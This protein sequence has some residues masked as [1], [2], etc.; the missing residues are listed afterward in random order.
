MSTNLKVTICGDVC[1]ECPRY[2]ATQEND[3]TSLEKIAELWYKLGL[4][5]KI[6][7]ADELKCFGCTKD[8][9]CTHQLNKCV[10]LTNKNN[11]GECD[12]FPCDKI[13]TVFSKTEDFA[14]TCK[15]ICTAEEFQSLE[16]A[17]LLKKKILVQIHNNNLKN[18]N[19]T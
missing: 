3:T 9:F 15:Q 17:F 7:P 13:N 10:H 5:D 2:I 14:K 18:N 8:K 6:L 19:Q 11:C 1:T 4:R 16:K 12:I